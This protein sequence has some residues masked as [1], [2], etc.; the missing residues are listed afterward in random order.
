MGDRVYVVVN[1]EDFHTMDSLVDVVYA[2]TDK[3]KAFGLASGNRYIQTTI[4]VL[5]NGQKIELH[6]YNSALE[7][8]EQKEL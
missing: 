6:E 1:H 7:E 2:G 4:T 3:D 5:E 8:W